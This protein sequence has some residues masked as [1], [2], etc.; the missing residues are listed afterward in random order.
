MVVRFSSHGGEVRAPA[1][2]R[3]DLAEVVD[4]RSRLARGTA[5]READGRETHERGAIGRGATGRANTAHGSPG[6]DGSPAGDTAPGHFDRGRIAPVTP[7]GT[8]PDPL[9]RAEVDS[10]ARAEP[11]TRAESPLDAVPEPDSVEP[12]PAGPETAV[13]EDGVRLLA[14]KA[15]SSGELRAELVRIGH[16]AHDVDAMILEFEGNL[17]LDDLGLARVLV[18]KLREQKRASRAQ[19]RVKLRGRLLPDGVIETVLGELDDDEEQALLAQTARDRT[20]RLMELDRATA[21][22]RLLGFLARRGWAGESAM[23]A[24]REALDAAGI[25]HGRDEAPGSSVR[26]R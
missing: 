6:G 15:R 16:D 9:P 26:F 21:E 14:R 25:R 2:E 17:Y 18:E 5:G 11:G 20:R 24:A 22:R 1:P 8:E 12:D 19:L 3:A 4:L 13:A 10:I 23:R 7:L